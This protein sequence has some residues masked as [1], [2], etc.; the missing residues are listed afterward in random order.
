MRVIV[1]GGDGY[2]GWA[3]T[4]RLIARGYEVV[5]VD[6][7]YTR[8]AVEECGSTSALP[9]LNTV[10]RAKAI[11]EIFDGNYKFYMADVTDYHELYK[12]IEESKPDAIVHFAEQ[13]SAPY[14]MR[15]A[16]HAAYTM[17]NNIVSTINLIYAVKEIDKNIHIVKM[18]TLGEY[19]TPNF[20]IPESAFVDAHINDKKDSI[21]VPKFA[22]S[23]YHWSKVH[24]T[25]NLIF[26]NKL[27]GITVTDIMQG[28]VYGSRT[29][30]IRDERLFT[31]LDFDETWGTVL[32]RF[33]VEAVLGLPLTVYGRGGQTRG[34]L[35]LE[36]SVEALARLIEHPPE[37]GGYRVVNQFTQAYSINELAK[38]VSNAAA[39]LGIEV[40]ADHIE[41]P[42]VEK[43]EHYYNPERKVL[44]SLGLSKPSVDIEDAVYEIIRDLSN[45]KERLEAY[46]EVIMPKVRWR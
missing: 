30:D 11:K 24:D 25:N 37:T 28:P 15:S 27:W 23:W 26:A 44:P 33:C 41:N 19:G 34:F 8:R 20:D 3:L 4:L 1:L 45:Y 39:K 36:D 40:K 18:G 38:I 43:E 10:E 42:R 5:A 46:K 35:S 31:R 7:L 14:S 12:I 29:K 22:N 13:R 6:N 17:Y 9:I 32:N 21:I 16:R 2:L